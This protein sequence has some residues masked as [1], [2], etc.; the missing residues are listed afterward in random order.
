MDGILTNQYLH[1]FYDH[2]FIRPL[3]IADRWFKEGEEKYTAIVSHGEKSFRTKKIDLHA[4]AYKAV[5]TD[6]NV[7]YYTLFSY[8]TCQL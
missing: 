3:F 7:F 2:L 1:Y 5:H 6:I 4:G 8:A